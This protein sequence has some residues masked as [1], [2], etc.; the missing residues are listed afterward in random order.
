MPRVHVSGSVSYDTLLAV[1]ADFR[2]TMKGNECSLSVGYHCKSRHE[3]FG[4]NAANIAFHLVRLGVDARPICAVGFDF[5]KYGDWMAKNKINQDLLHVNDSEPTA[6]VYVL[7]DAV[8]NQILTLHLGA[9]KYSKDIVVPRDTVDIAVVGP[10]DRDALLNRIDGFMRAASPI[11][12]DPGQS[13][14]SLSTSD[15]QFAIDSSRWLIANE[16]E[17]SL[18]TRQLGTKPEEIALSL[19]ALIVTCGSEGSRV[20]ANGCIEHVPAVPV[21]NPKDP[22]GCG[23]SFRAG[24]ISG[25]LRGVDVVQSATLGASTASETLAH[26]GAQWEQ[27]NDTDSS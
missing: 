14:T 23:D 27:A 10:D 19:D 7:T 6:H 20:Y 4:G 1:D 24:L 16:F 9:M 13:T 15:L 2:N 18:I 11:M 5:E 26:V 12:F 3:T 25:L 21:E 22:T 8:D 17:M